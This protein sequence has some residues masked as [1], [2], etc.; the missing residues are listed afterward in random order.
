M[1]SSLIY[2]S[3][4]GLMYMLI[5]LYP[6]SDERLNLI[7]QVIMSFGVLICII[8]L[9]CFILKVMGITLN[10]NNLSIVNAVIAFFLFLKIKKRGRLQQF[11][12]DRTDLINVLILSCLFVVLF[13][14]I[15]S[16]DLRLCYLNSDI[17]NHFNYALSFVEGDNSDVGIMYLTALI[18]ATVIN[19]FKPLM[20]PIYYYKAFIVGDAL[21]NWFG[22][23]MFYVTLT[24][25]VRRNVFKRFCVIFS[26]LFGL[27]YPIYSYLIGGFVY[28]SLGA[29]LI[30]FLIYILDIYSGNRTVRKEIE[31]LTILAFMAIGMSYTLFVPCV[32]AASFVYFVSVLKMEGNLLRKESVFLFLKMYII[33]SLFIIM[34][35]VFWMM[36]GQINLGSLKVDGGIYSNLYSDFWPLIPFVLYNL[37]AGGKRGKNCNQIFLLIFG[38]ITAFML[39]C[40][41]MG[42]ISRYYYYKMYYPLWIFAWIETAVAVDDMIQ[43]K[44]KFLISYVITCLVIL[45]IGLTPIDEKIVEKNSKMQTVEGTV[46]IFPIYGFMLPYIVNGFA[47]Y[48]TEDNLNLY[49]YVVEVLQNKQSEVKNIPCIASKDRQGDCFW[50]SAFTRNYSIGY[51]QLIREK[52][53]SDE[54][55]DKMETEL[56]Y[57]VMFKTSDI[58]KENIDRLQE[59]NIEYENTTTVIYT[60][61]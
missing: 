1:I 2:V 35:I 44:E 21:I 61:H 60:T 16:I 30:A 25:F 20:D 14:H 39:M 48:D 42:I 28:W 7:K 36:R 18:N 52:G 15:F 4:F 57:F 34:G 17:A 11:F 10:L 23:M 53:L 45:G 38:I 27:G 55:T 32:F 59:Y 22:L 12:L 31:I 58:Y 51:F 37:F 19:I 3:I 9:P 43:R 5:L 49:K 13:I 24:H 47:P 40:C 46:S 26:V 29:T 41:H 56:D 50:Y 6:K 33:P 8:A 54:V